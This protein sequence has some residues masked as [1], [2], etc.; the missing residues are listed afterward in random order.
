M[1][2]RMTSKVKHSEKATR[3]TGGDIVREDWWVCHKKL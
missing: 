2:D 1:N 3:N